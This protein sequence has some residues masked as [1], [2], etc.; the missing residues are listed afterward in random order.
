MNKLDFLRKLDKYLEV[1]DREERREILSFYEERFYTGT[2]YEN[3]TEEEV[4][5]ELESPEAIAR[6]VLAEYG[7]SPKYVKTKAERN[8][9]SNFGQIV[10][11]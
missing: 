9:N 6:N 8:T 4:I 1:L 5:A 11:L 10:L 3:K 7:A 2:I